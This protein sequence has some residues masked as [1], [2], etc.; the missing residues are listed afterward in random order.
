MSC[1]VKAAVQLALAAA[2][3]FQSS[4]LVGASPG[5][6]TGAGS[7][8]GGSEN[9]VLT[10]TVSYSSGS[11]SS[12]GGDGCVWAMADDAYSLPAG[13]GQGSFP[14]TDAASGVTYHLWTKSCPGQLVAYVQLPDAEPRDLLPLLLERLRS[15]ELPAPL[16]VFELLDPEFGWAYVKTPLDFRVGG[17]A[18]RTVSVT[19]SFGPVWATVTAVPSSLTFDPG[20]P[21]GPGPV[22]CG[23]DGPTAAYV[24]EFPGD[25]SYTY[26]NASS[27]SPFDGYHFVTS[28]A[29]E[30]SISWTSSTGAGGPLAGFATSSTAQLAVAEVKG[31]VVCTGARPGQGG[32]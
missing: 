6:G 23:G 22:S 7:G 21:A 13:Q 12:D 25:C 30:W 19:A 4:G 27:T 1:V 16:P 14:F 31:L 17:D 11:G 29:I 15:T 18:W 26:V 5:D 28:L 32:C 8:T 3:L 24:A 20:D 2:L 10:A 9:G